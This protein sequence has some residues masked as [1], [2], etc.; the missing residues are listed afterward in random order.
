MRSTGLRGVV[1][2]GEEAVV[3]LPLVV[4][5]GLEDAAGGVAQLEHRADEG[6]AEATGLA[7]GSAVACFALCR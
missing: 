6:H 5:R 3:A 1:R 2:I 4:R 7:T